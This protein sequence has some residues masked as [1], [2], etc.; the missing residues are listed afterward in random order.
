[1]IKTLTTIALVLL[2][3]LSTSAQES[4]S[5]SKDKGAETSPL[6]AQLVEV[7]KIWTPER[8]CMRTDLVRYRRLWFCRFQNSNPSV[9]ETQISIIYSKDG[10]SWKSA[11]LLSKAGLPCSRFTVKSNEHLMLFSTADSRDPKAKERSIGWSSQDG[12]DWTAY[13]PAI[14][15]DSRLSRMAWHEDRWFGVAG[16]RKTRRG[17]TSLV[18]TTDGKRFKTHVSDFPAGL[19]YE[20]S[21]VF[22]QQDTAFCL[23]SMLQTPEQIRP[24][25]RVGSA[26]SPYRKWSWKQLDEW[27]VD[28]NMIA[29][30][31]DRLVVAGRK[32]D[33]S[34]SLAFPKLS[35]ITL[36]SLEPVTGTL[37]E[38]L[39]LR[40]GTELST[41]GSPGL[42]W[43]DDHLW[44]SYNSSH[45]LDN[46]K[47]RTLIYL[48]KVKLTENGGTE[49]GKRRSNR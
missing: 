23:L 40:S 26:V 35:Q 12:F 37:T 10:R 20:A 13:E 28:P 22:S 49:N 32:Y 36:W 18:T 38:M 2:C 11:A 41:C 47:S 48:A 17:T 39:S 43:Y 24:H 14:E 4:P 34:T 19:Y 6:Q 1:M 21:I 31:D 7:R 45:E 29:L 5:A 27:L 8:P 9:G 42:V 30:P 3:A 46:S 44:I 15:G 25:G 16:G 33:P